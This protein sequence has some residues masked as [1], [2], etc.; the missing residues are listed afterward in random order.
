LVVIQILPARKEACSVPISACA[1]KDQ[2][3][4]R[5]GAMENGSQESFVTYRSIFAHVF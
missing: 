4:L 3:K 2:I 5:H 1:E